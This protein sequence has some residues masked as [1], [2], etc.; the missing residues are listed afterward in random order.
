[1]IRMLDEKEIND[2]AVTHFQV[3]DSTGVVREFVTTVSDGL[4]APAIATIELKGDFGR[5][6]REDLV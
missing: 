1:M 5:R 2:V 6:T 3:V 4:F